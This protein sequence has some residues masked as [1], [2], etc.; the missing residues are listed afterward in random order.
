MAEALDP[1]PGY[2]RE[3][4]L[5]SRMGFSSFQSQLTA[6]SI[7]DRWREERK[8]VFGERCDD[9][10]LE[11]R[12]KMYLGEKSDDVSLEREEQMYLRRERG[13]D[14]S[15]ERERGE[16]GDVCRQIYI[17]KRHMQT[18]EQRILAVDRS[19]ERPDHYP[20]VYPNSRDRWGI[21]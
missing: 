6:G 14:I 15:L 17:S 2:H 4:E 7:G 9:V 19:F 18:L 8:Y 16:D 21:S 10:L 11:T 20:F 1:L 3:L 5:D 13:E 12:E